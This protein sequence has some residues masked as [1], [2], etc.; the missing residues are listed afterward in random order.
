MEGGQGAQRGCQGAQEGSGCPDRVR[1]PKE[2]VRVPMEGGQSAHGGVGVPRG[3][4]GVHGGGQ[5]AQSRVSSQG[6]RGCQWGTQGVRGTLPARGATAG[7]GPM[8][9]GGDADA[10]VVTGVGGTGG[11]GHVAELPCKGDT[12]VAPIRAPSVM[13]PS[14]AWPPWQHPEWWHP[15]GHPVWWHPSGHVDSGDM[16]VVGT[17]GW[18]QHGD[19][20]GHGLGGTKLG[21]GDTGDGAGAGRVCLGCPRGVARVEVSPGGGVPGGRTLVPRG[22][23]AVEPPHHGGAGAPV[24]AGL[25]G[26]GVLTVGARGPLP[27]RL[28]LAGEPIGGGGHTWVLGTHRCPQPAYPTPG[29]HGHL[30]EHPWVP[31]PW[32]PAPTVLTGTHISPLSPTWAPPQH[33]PPA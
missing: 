19:T 2:V 20:R 22:A 21:H 24:L 10:S 13:A 33:P 3:G 6:A 8:V 27:A 12:W 29:I 30:Q 32:H 31:P 5:G 25:G 4:Q 28:A 1:V 11:Q 7:E 14:S 16:S 9:R 26:T 23:G 17:Q 15:A 18:W